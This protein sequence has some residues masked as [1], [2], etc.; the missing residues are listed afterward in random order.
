MLS[1]NDPEAIDRYPDKE[2][3]IAD[4]MREVGDDLPTLQDWAEA[5]LASKSYADLHEMVR[6]MVEDSY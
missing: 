4:I 5:W 3:L 1:I 2:D 6:D